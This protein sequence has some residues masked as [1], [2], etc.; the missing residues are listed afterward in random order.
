[1][2]HQEI[3][4]GNYLLMQRIRTVAGSPE[5]RGTLRR[6]WSPAE[7]PTAERFVQ[8]PSSGGGQMT[9]GECHVDKRD[10]HWPDNRAAIGTVNRQAAMLGWRHPFQ[11]PWSKHFAVLWISFQGQQIVAPSQA[12]EPRPARVGACSMLSPG[13]LAHLAKPHLD[14]FGW[15]LPWAWM[16]VSTLGHC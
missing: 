16:L 9:W 2:Y 13:T 12:P 8:V 6:K 3:S 11:D 14:Y 10:A 7:H 15:S 4:T 5:G 1:M